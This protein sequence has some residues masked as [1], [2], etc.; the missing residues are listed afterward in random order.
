MTVVQIKKTT[1]GLKKC[2]IKRKLTFEDYKNCFEVTQ[3]ENKIIHLEKNEIDVG[4]LRK[5][6]EFIK[7]I[8]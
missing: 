6:K 4:S 2:V 8:N 7:T 3:L 5:D 1:T